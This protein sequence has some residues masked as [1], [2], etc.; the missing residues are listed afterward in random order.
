MT[1]LKFDLQ[2]ANLKKPIIQHHFTIRR[3]TPQIF[4]F[5]SRQTANSNVYLPAQDIIS[6]GAK[7]SYHIQFNISS[8]ASTINE[9]LNISSTNAAFLVSEQI[10]QSSSCAVVIYHGKHRKTQVELLKKD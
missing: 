10:A 4:I 3:N 8:S 6:S 1:M 7:I 5:I 9:T 2:A